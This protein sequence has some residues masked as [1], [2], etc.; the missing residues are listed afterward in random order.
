MGSQPHLVL[1]N[2][3]NVGEGGRNHQ[4]RYIVLSGVQTHSPSASEM[5][6]SQ[7]G[8]VDHLQE[9]MWAPQTWNQLWSFQKSV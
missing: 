3:P 9:V 8:T 7:E 6:H 4:M 2:A 1:D 5:G